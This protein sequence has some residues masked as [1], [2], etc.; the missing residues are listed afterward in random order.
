MRKDENNSKTL[1]A[2]QLEEQNP[3]YEQGYVDGFQEFHS[4]FKYRLFFYLIIG[5]L[6]GLAGGF[7]IFYGSFSLSDQSEAKTQVL[8]K[9]PAQREGRYKHATQAAQKYT[10][11]ILA[12]YEDSFSQ[13]YTTISSGSGFILNKEGCIVTNRHVVEGFA[14]FRILWQGRLYRGELIGYSNKADIAVLKFN[15]PEMTPALTLEKKEVFQ[16]EEVLA[17]GSPYGFEATVTQGIVS[18]V[19]RFLEDGTAIPYLQTDCAINR[20]N[21]GGP[22]V[23]LQGQVVGMNHLIYSKSG[24]STGIGF[25][26]PIK[27]VQEVAKE[28]IESAKEQGRHFENQVIDY[29]QSLEQAF[30]GVI[31]QNS[32]S[33]PGVIVK[34]VMAFSAADHAGIEAGD[35]I[36]NLEGSAIKNLNDLKEILL[37]YRPGEEVELK[38]RREEEEEKEITLHVTLGERRN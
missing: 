9:F 4:A 11:S 24:E 32:F 14:S 26:I 31:G 36:Y 33:E 28:I 6:L 18:F 21:S 34:E 20:G 23:N 22:L 3:D 1:L 38:I 17:I 35:L 15:A 16:S 27:I 5:L 10:L 13:G 25:A 37:H 29:G 2:H 30:L 12:G 19:G 7:F 8:E